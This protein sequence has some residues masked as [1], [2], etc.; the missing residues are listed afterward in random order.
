M[1]H[2]LQR[3]R[4]REPGWGGVAP[5][6]QQQWKVITTPRWKSLGRELSVEQERA[7]GEGLPERAGVVDR[8][9]RKPLLKSNSTGVYREAEHPILPHQILRVPAN[10]LQWKEWKAREQGSLVMQTIE[11]NLQ[12]HRAG[13]IMGA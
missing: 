1:Q 12:G 10:P 13:E 2:Y 6:D 5:R 3:C 7:V 9:T 4:L 8:G 11:V